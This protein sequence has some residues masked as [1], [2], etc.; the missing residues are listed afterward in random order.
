M[1][2]DNKYK[3]FIR[4]TLPDQTESHAARRED[5]WRSRNGSSVWPF[6]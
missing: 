5:Q 3:S 4:P 1:G 2:W 6:A